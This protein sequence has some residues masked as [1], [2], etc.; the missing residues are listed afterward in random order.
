MDF[1]RISER[2]IKLRHILSKREVDAFFLMVTEGYNWESAYYISGFR[3]SSC[4][5]LVSNDDSVLITDGRYLK[6]AGDQ[7]PFSIV[8]QAGRSMTSVVMEE[9]NKSGLQNIGFESDRITLSQYKELS[10]S[11]NQWRDLKGVIPQMRRSKDEIEILLIRKAAEIALAAFEKTLKSAYEGMKEQEFSNWLEFNMKDLGAEGGWPGHCFIVASGPRSA[12]PHGVP[13]T[14]EFTRGDWVTVDFG[15]AFKGYLSDITKNF[16]IG[17]PTEEAQRIH[18]VLYEAHIKAAESLKPGVTGKDVDAL[19]RDVIKKAGYE[20]YF[21]HGLGHSFGLEI[22][23]R[24]RLSFTSDDVLMAGD[25]V[26]IE[27]GIYIE[28]LGG[29]RI[30]DD[31]LVTPEGCICLTGGPDKDLRS[32]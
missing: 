31:Y 26:T 32:I 5:I 14:R 10:V 13:T 19:A 11:G 18:S 4:S 1:Q 28:G 7:T 22:H 24:P 3:G 15:A 16:I 12:L 30:E 20:K 23:E 17:D 9:I 21:T 6:Q 25:V 29:M 8:D 27:P 2:I